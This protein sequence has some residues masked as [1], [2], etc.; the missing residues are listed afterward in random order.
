M[1]ST[2]RPIGALHHA[3]RGLLV[4]ALLLGLTTSLAAQEPTRL[5][6]G[7]AIRR[8]ER[9][10][11]AVRI[12]RAATDRA[13]AGAGQARSQRLPQLTSSAAYQRA[14]QLQFQE[15]T[16]RLG[17]GSDGGGEGSGE[18]GDS[19][20]DSPLARVF[21]SPNTIILGLNASQVLYAGGAL[22]AS[23]AAASAS[24]RAAALA[25]QGARAQ[26]VLDVAQ[27]YFDAQ[28]AAQLAVIAESS[29]VQADRALT[30]T[31]L[32]REVGSVSE[33]DL[34][35]AR[36]QRDNVRPALIGAR[37][38]RDVALLRLKQ[39][40]DLPSAAP[41]ELA[42]SVEEAAE[43]TA[44]SLGAPRDLPAADAAPPSVTER[45]PVR[46]AAEA[47]RAQEHLL[48]VARGQR[49]PSIAL[50]S[51]YQRFAYPPEGTILEDEWRLFFPNWTVTLGVQLPLF[52]GGRITNDI[53]AAEASLL[54][55]RARYDQVQDAA[56]LD[57]SLALAQLAQAEATYEASVGT[58]TQAARAYAIAE[59]R[60]AEGL[61][62][63]LELAQTRVDLETARAN[64]VQATRDVALARLRLALL[65]DL[66]LT[67][68]MPAGGR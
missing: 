5:T 46:Q 13:R 43:A 62:T 42:T 40:L 49:R 17:G 29:Y 55:A 2:T 3:L 44:T 54:E 34:I 26:L 51:N 59:V 52:T 24:V 30:Q 63:Q 48:R 27:A 41:L 58:D 6:L 37:T 7:D 18:G 9:G 11:E 8:A 38:Q 45:V 47:V 50:Q 33:F 10:S 67:P 56:E 64:R 16:K 4:P 61:A 65:T 23:E 1:T 39:L 28:V 36:V 57:R 22:A 35:R 15:I 66:P 68:A 20:A 60:F 12:A 31:Q 32:G 14:I 53:R 19:F 25:E 21:A